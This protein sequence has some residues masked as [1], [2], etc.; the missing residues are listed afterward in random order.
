MG[1][2]TARRTLFRYPLGQYVRIVKNRWH[3]FIKPTIRQT[4]KRFL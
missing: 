3:G 1:K 4:L 2:H